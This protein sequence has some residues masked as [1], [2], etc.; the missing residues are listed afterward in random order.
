MPNVMKRKT[1]TTW[2]ALHDR[3]TEVFRVQ[4][5]AGLEKD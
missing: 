4:G 1:R 3:K 2:E 5:R